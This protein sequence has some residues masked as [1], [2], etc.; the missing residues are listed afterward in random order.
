LIS[1]TSF[2]VTKEGFVSDFGGVPIKR[3]FGLDIILES[4]WNFSLFFE[5]VLLV[6]TSYIIKV[7]F[8]LFNARIRFIGILKEIFDFDFLFKERVKF[9]AEFNRVLNLFSAPGT[10]LFR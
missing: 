1:K 7:D 8:D 2:D 9:N 3:G 6:N 10:Y 5:S 4:E